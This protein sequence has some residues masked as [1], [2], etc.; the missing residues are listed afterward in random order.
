VSRATVVVDLGFGDAGKGSIVDFLV[1]QDEQVGTVVRFNGGPQAAHRVV[2]HTW[3]VAHERTH[4]FAQFGAGT[5]VPGVRT[6]LA[7]GMLVNPANLMVEY[8]ALRKIGVRDALARLTVDPNCVVVTPWHVVANRAIEAARGDGRHGS[9]G[10]GVGEARY[11]ELAGVALRAGECSSRASLIW[12]LGEIREMAASKLDG[13]DLPA[14]SLLSRRRLFSDVFLHEQVDALRDPRWLGRVTNEHALAGYAESGSLVFEGA[15]GVLLDERH[16]F[17][18]YTTWTDTTTRNA[19]DLLDEI[20]MLDETTTV[21]VT[22]AYATRHGAGPLP[23]EDADLTAL[24]P[25]AEN[26]EGRWQG[27]WRVGWLDLPLLRYALRVCPVDALALTCVDRV[28]S[29][30]GFRVN[31]FYRNVSELHVAL[32]TCD[33]LEHG[34]RLC[35][36]LA[37]AEPVYFPAPTAPDDLANLLQMTTGVPVA[38]ISEGPTYSDKTMIRDLAPTRSLATRFPL[39]RDRRGLAD[40]DSLGERRTT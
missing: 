31:A 9:C 26:V 38:V 7:R 2:E 14:E 6:H 8:T 12:R 32:P 24:L 35:A 1:R 39:A 13:I 18:P 25:D 19:L 40:A 33:P 21:G 36:R 5:L 27:A 16:G 34:H 20:G 30:D 37:E 10:Q 11:D 29:I 17:H 3:K 23:T 4:V 15:Q 22:R 28:Q